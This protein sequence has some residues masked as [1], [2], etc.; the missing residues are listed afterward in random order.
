M[1]AEMT[2]SPLDYTGIPPRE[3]RQILRV[4][5]GASHFSHT[6]VTVPSASRTARN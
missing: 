3:E 6:E 5:R 1:R 2:V 4:G